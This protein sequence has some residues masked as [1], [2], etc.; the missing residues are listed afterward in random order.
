MLSN[1]FLCTRSCLS[2]ITESRQLRE[3]F[4]EQRRGLI[5]KS[6]LVTLPFLLTTK[7][8]PAQGGSYEL[9]PSLDSFLVGEKHQG[10][11]KRKNGRTGEGAVF[12]V[13]QIGAMKARRGQL[14]SGV[15]LRRQKET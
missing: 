12:A 3:T 15:G 4:A 5:K 8:R 13:G 14:Q 9:C 11:R 10:S 7:R 2:N 6:L 1:L